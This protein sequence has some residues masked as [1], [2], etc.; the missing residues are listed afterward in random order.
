VG[1]GVLGILLYIINKEE[2]MTSFNFDLVGLIEPA[3][4]GTY[5][6]AKAYLEQNQTAFGY[7]CVPIMIA[8][9][10]DQ[11]RFDSEFGIFD[12]FQSGEVA[13]RMKD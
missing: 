1:V 4:F 13:Y 11:R 5:K 3:C 2:N 6:E 12:H 8:D 7:I 9:E 10:E